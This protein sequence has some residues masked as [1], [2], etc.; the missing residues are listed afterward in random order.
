MYTRL[1]FWIAYSSS[2]PWRFKVQVPSVKWQ[3]LCRPDA[4]PPW[5]CQITSRL[6]ILTLC[7]CDVNVHLL[8]RGQWQTGTF[9][10][11]QLKHFWF[12]T[13]WIYEC[14]TRGSWEPS[15][16]AF[17]YS[18][19]HP[20]AYPLQTGGDTL[21]QGVWQGYFCAQWV[22]ERCSHAAFKKDILECKFE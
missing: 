10:Q 4:Q 21:R 9:V 7:R 19:G 5:M 13:G 1:D 2:N 17:V 6:F 20:P 22:L 18:Y 12:V 15:I 3:C 11:M 14:R 16:H 8:S